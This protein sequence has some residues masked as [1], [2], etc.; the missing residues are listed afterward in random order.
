MNLL[1]FL[2]ISRFLRRK[3][4]KGNP[5]FHFSKTFFNSFFEQICQIFNHPKPSMNY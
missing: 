4:G 5:F 3:F 1:S 2:I